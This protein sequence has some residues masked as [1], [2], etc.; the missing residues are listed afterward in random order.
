MREL[1]LRGGAQQRDE[2]IAVVVVVISLPVSL[3]KSGRTCFFLRPM[4]YIP[5]A[6]GEKEGKQVSYGIRSSILS[7]NSGTVSVLRVNPEIR[8][9]V[10]LMSNNH[11]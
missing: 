3:T 10:T 9:Q 8:T 4:G 2:I 5:Q 7:S 11:A 1:H 6:E